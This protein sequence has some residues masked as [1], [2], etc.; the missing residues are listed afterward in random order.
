MDWQGRIVTLSRA[1]KTRPAMDGFMRAALLLGFVA[2]LGA[3]RSMTYDLQAKPA[4]PL[5]TTNAPYS[6]AVET[7]SWSHY[8]F[9][10]LVPVAKFDLN[11]FLLAEIRKGGNK[12]AVGIV[13]VDESNSFSTGLLTLLTLGIYRPLDI[14]A[15]ANLHTKVTQP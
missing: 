2:I 8:L 5:A 4:V 14:H 11:E 13:R 7:D 9:W 12:E 10:G 1:S 6:R 3:C 15:S